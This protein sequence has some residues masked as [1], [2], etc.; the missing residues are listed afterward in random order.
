[1]FVKRYK[2]S[3]ETVKNTKIRYRVFVAKSMYYLIYQPKSSNILTRLY[4]IYTVFIKKYAM[5]KSQKVVILI[6]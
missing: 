4:R 2:L 3:I 1:M 6:S 5:F